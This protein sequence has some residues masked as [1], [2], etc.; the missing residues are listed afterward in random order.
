MYV[1]AP[2][3]RELYAEAGFAAAGMRL[4]FLPG[5]EGSMWSI[6]HE[7]TLRPMAEITAEIAAQTPD[8]RV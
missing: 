1:N 7:L 6:L 8:Y 4:H 3:G 2:D 5:W